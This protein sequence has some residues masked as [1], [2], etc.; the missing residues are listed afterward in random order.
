MNFDKFIWA[1]TSYQGKFH[2][3][4]EWL[5]LQCS[6]QL[7]A[8]SLM[9]EFPRTVLGAHSQL[10]S[11]TPVFYQFPAHS[12]C[13]GLQLQLT[14]S[15]ITILWRTRQLHLCVS[16]APQNQYVQSSSIW[17]A[18]KMHR[19]YCCVTTTS[20]KL[21]WKSNCRSSLMV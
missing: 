5:Y 7:Y 12:Y 14:E 1:I 6:S 2:F 4:R 3:I 18:R 20:K 17:S 19:S 8:S 9:L 13:L 11:Y 15:H 16:R 21:N 10:T